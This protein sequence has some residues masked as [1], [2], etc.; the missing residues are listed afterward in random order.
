MP[1]P[2]GHAV[3]VK[4]QL[5]DAN[6]SLLG[7]HWRHSGPGE[8]LKLQIDQ[9][10]PQSF[11]LS[12][13]D[14]V[15]RLLKSP[16]TV[17]FVIELKNELAIDMDCSAFLDCILQ[18]VYRFGSKR[19]I[20]FTSFNPALCTALA[21]KQD[22]YPIFFLIDI[23]TTNKSVPGDVRSASLQNAMHFARP[24]GIAGVVAACDPFVLSST[25]LAKVN[26]RG[27]VFWK[28]PENMSDEYDKSAA[29]QSEAV[30]DFL[31]VNH[32]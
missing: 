7:T 13:Q 9:T 6:L 20:V 4:Q 8:R 15:T 1:P 16:T 30:L 11:A 21:V 24:F 18:T 12:T 27:L 23:P 31:V 14:L 32:R 26:E 29:K 19:T 10:A 5:S 17:P 25:L 22:T 28:R 2:P 3:P